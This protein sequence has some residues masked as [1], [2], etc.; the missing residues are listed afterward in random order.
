[1]VDY[2]NQSFDHH[3]VTIED[4]IEYYHEHRKSIMT[5]REIGTDVGSFPE[6]MR[7][8]LRMDPDVVLLGEMRDIETMSTA[9]TAAE[10]GHLVLGTMHTT[11][12]ARTI[13]RIIDAYPPDQQEQ[14]RAQLSVSLLAV[15]SQVI[16]PRADQQGLIAAFEIMIMTPAIENL[17][18]KNETFKI[19]STLQTSKPMGMVMLDDYLWDIYK[20][21]KIDKESML[22]KCQDPKDLQRKLDFDE[23]GGAAGQAA[24]P[25]PPAGPAAPAQPPEKEKSPSQGESARPASIFSRRKEG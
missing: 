3:I 14:C 20:A 16:M 13:D 23:L 5:Q 2:I 22:L 9:I 21:G 17:V 12:S 4:P 18:R 24:A 11:G 8:V 1:M 7:R 10:T 19:R 6:A 15:I 25:A